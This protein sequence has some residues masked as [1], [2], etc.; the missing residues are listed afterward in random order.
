MSPSD[1]QVA[2]ASTDAENTAIETT[3]G[4]DD[5]LQFKKRLLSAGWPVLAIHFHTGC[6]ATSQSGHV[7]GLT[8]VDP[9]PFNHWR[10]HSRTAG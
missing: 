7:S 10:S 4:D 8:T 5:A 3:G 9:Q 1:G 2:P 6:E